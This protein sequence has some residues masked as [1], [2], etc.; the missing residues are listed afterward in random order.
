MEGREGLTCREIWSRCWSRCRHRP[1]VNK[2]DRICD[3]AS[4]LCSPPSW[5]PCELGAVA[6]KSQGVWAG[7]LVFGDTFPFSLLSTSSSSF[8]HTLDFSQQ[9][10]LFN[11]LLTR[12]FPRTGVEVRT[13]E[14]DGGKGWLCLW[15]G[16]VG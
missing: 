13:Q 3:R 5:A 16:P 7:D 2:I 12:G 6:G 10:K 9:V 11:P 8:Q 1:L 14:R 4:G 15:P